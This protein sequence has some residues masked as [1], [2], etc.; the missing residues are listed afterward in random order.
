M[1]SQASLLSKPLEAPLPLQAI[2]VRTTVGQKM[3][4][5]S[6]LRVLVVDSKALLSHALVLLA[7]PNDVTYVD[8]H[9]AALREFQERPYDIAFLAVAKS[10]LHTFVIAA[11]MRC[12]E[13][14]ERPWRQCA[15]VIACTLT[16]DNYRDCLVAGSGLSGALNAPWSRQAVHTCLS[17]WRADKYLRAV[18]L[19]A[20]DG[21]AENRQGRP[22]A[23]FRGRS[24]DALSAVAARPGG[25]KSATR[26]TDQG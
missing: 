24:T 10:V 7:S 2:Q 17:L 11:H 5:G 4:F 20:I 6:V 3:E 15:A 23:R 1:R 12:I 9:E 21:P 14:E 13:R 18:P 19:P 8:G 25:A 22:L 16:V 26:A